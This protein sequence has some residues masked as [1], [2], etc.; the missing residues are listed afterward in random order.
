M[1]AHVERVEWTRSTTVSGCV[2]T[3][4]CAIL[5]ASRDADAWK[6]FRGWRRAVRYI[7]IRSNRSSPALSRQRVRPRTR[8]RRKE[9][10]EEAKGH[11]VARR[12]I[13]IRA[14]TTEGA[15]V[16]DFGLLQGFATCTLALVGSGPSKDAG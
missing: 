6:R 14:S 7:C 10:E 3:F 12:L 8:R 5:D 1:G 15:R 13:G 2:W 11:S 9:E 4:V 16:E